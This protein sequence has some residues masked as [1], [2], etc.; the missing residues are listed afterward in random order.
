MKFS[1]A[2]DTFFHKKYKKYIS[3]MEKIGCFP[4]YLQV[5]RER[6]WRGLRQRLESLVGDADGEGLHVDYPDGKKTFFREI[7]I[8]A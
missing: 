8:R 5:R 1:R 7:R 2:R 6:P 4:I 3:D